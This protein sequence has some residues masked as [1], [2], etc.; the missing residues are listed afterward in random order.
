VKV[1]AGTAVLLMAYGTPKSLDEIEPYLTDIRQGRKPTQEAVEEL[2]S[3]YL[4]IGGRSPLLEITSAQAAD[5]EKQL[6]SMGVRTRVY[7]GMKHWHPYIREVVP[8]IINDGYDRIV[9]LVLAPHY[10]QMSI[11]GYK[12]ALQEAATASGPLRV[13]LIESWYD[14]PLFHRAVQEKIENAL[15]QFGDAGKVELLFTAHSLPERI[16]TTHDPYPTQLES[17]C[18]SVANRLSRK[19]WSFAYQSAG[20]TEDKWLGPDIIE[21]LRELQ[22]ERRRS[23]VLV[24]PIGFV[25]DHLEI[26]YDLDVE[27]QEFAQS[28]NLT[29]KRTESLNT[30]PTFISALTEIVRKRSDDQSRS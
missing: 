21:F 2:T 11:G 18:R 13:D 6:A 27:V 20:Q 16:L 5:V 8:Q 28:I 29:L 24:V 9:C 15:G 25:A 1:L 14:H 10:S 22:P 23:G 19:E 26:L 12:Q 7:F 3:R 4:R 30:S 17:S